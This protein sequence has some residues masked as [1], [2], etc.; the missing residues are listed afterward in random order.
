MIPDHLS[1][2]LW[3]GGANGE[4]DP[5]FVRGTDEDG[6][7]QMFRRIGV[8][9]TIVAVAL[10]LMALPALAS[11]SNGER[12][13]EEASK[14]KRNT[15]PAQEEASE[16]R[17]PKQSTAPKKSS[18]STRTR[19]VNTASLSQISVDFD[20]FSILVN[21]SLDISNIVLKLADGTELKIEGL[22]GNSFSHTTDLEILGV[23]VKAGSNSSGDGP[24]YGTW[25]ASDATCSQVAGGSLTN[26]PTVEQEGTV[27]S[28]M[29]EVL[30][31]GAT[32]AP[33]TTE[34]L[35]AGF[36]RSTA[37]KG[38]AVLGEQLVRGQALAATGID[39]STLLLAGL[40]LAIAGLIMVRMSKTQ[41]ETVAPA[42]VIWE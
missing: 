29:I 25:F 5:P 30:S 7:E 15:A 31:A 26:T 8:Y 10:S 37:P 38:T 12:G 2:R 40:L 39:S 14:G 4:T 1:G 36:M 35:G 16:E 33:Q 32:L 17:S 22:S 19:S 20:C 6:K 24:G 21:S 42:G 11:P 41:S 18:G 34:V 13:R 23:W 9:F 3:T 27:T 28:P